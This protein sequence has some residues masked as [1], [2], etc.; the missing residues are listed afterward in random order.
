MAKT[1]SPPASAPA[2]KRPRGCPPKPGGRMSQVEVQRAY[3]ARLAAAGKVVRIVDAA[4]PALV[5]IPDAEFEAIRKRLH[6]ALLKLERRQQ[7]VARL[8]QR[9][10]YLEGELILQHQHHTNALKANVVLK[11]Q[12]AEMTQKLPKRRRV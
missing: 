3:R 10:A 2:V 5:S 6:D 12:L 11:K 7:D 9:N 8:E 4:K 1:P